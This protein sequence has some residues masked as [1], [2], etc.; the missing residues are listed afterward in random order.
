MQDASRL[1]RGCC[2]GSWVPLAGVVSAAFAGFGCGL[3]GSGDVP[4]PATITQEI[5]GPAPDYVTRLGDGPA[6]AVNGEDFILATT[7]EN[8]GDAAATVPSTT[9]YFLSADRVIDGGD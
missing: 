8:T 7:V 5:A 9:R 3:D 6:A 1:V 4:A 2:R